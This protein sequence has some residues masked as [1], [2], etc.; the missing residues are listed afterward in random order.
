MKDIFNRFILYL[1]LESCFIDSACK[2]VDE[3]GNERKI[4]AEFG[5]FLL[6]NT[7]T[8]EHII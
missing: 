7:G 8:N 2:L 4:G 3:T 5:A 6:E 1:L